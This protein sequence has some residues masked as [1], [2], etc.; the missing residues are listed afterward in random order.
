[1]LML[2]SKPDLKDWSHV[3]KELQGEL[4]EVAGGSADL[5]NDIEAVKSFAKG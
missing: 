5:V 3:P 4:I 1:L 2:V